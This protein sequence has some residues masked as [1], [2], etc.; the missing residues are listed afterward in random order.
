MWGKGKRERSMCLTENT[1]NSRVEISK[2]RETREWGK[3]S[4]ETMDL[5]NKPYVKNFK[6]NKKIC[7]GRI[8][9]AVNPNFVISCGTHKTCE[10]NKIIHAARIH[11]IQPCPWFL[12]KHLTVPMACAEAARGLLVTRASSPKYWPREHRAISTAPFSSTSDLPWQGN[13]KY[14]PLSLKTENV[15]SFIPC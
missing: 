5:K 11:E 8:Y 14:S 12:P 4:R 1:E 10:S 6:E 13:Q 15:L 3:Y 9:N 7:T 2:Q